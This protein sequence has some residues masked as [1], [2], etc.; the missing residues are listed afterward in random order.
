MVPGLTR[1]SAVILWIHTTRP[2][3]LP[4]STSVESMLKLCQA[5]LSI[6]S[7]LLPSVAIA[8]F[9]IKRVVVTS[10]LSWFAVAQQWEF[11]VGPTVGIAAGDQ[12]WAAR[13]IL[14][15]NKPHIHI[16]DLSALLFCI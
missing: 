4:V 1:P 15:V 6:C 14:E 12:L 2:A 16:T 13:Y 3:S 8:N 11:Q 5:R 10:N 9:S 7:M